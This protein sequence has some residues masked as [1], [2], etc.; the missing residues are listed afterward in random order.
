MVVILIAAAVLSMALGDHEDAIAIAAI[1]ALNALLGFSQEYRAE[2]AMSALKQLSIPIVR[3][4]RNNKVQ[5][6]SSRDVVPGDVVL[7]EAGERVAADCRLVEAARLETQEAALTGE[8]QPIQKNIEA[9]DQSELPLGDRHGMVYMGTFIVSGRGIGVAVA[10]GLATELGKIAR[11][12][13]SVRS[14]PTP[15]QHRLDQVGKRLA[16]IALFLVVVIFVLGMARGE[17]FRIMLL[18]AVSLGVAAVPEGLPAIVTIAL[19]LGAQRMLRRNALIR[20]LPAVEALGS[21]T[22]ICTDKTGTL[23]QNRM[24][25]ASLRTPQRRLELESHGATREADGAGFGLLLAAA[26]LCNDAFPGSSRNEGG[27]ILGDPTEVALLEAAGHFGIAKAH[28]ETVLPRVG[29]LPFSAERKRMTTFH[30]RQNSATAISEEIASALASDNEAGFIAFTKGA[31]E[32]LMECSAAIAVGDKKEV[33]SASWRERLIEENNELAQKGMRVLGIAYRAFPSLP[34]PGQMENAERDLTFIGMVAMMDPPRAEAALAV[35]T[36]KNAGI[37]PVMITGDHASTAQYIARQL[38]IDDGHPVVTGQE[39]DRL[40]PAAFDQRVEQTAV[41]AR[42]SPEHKLRIVEGLQRRGHIP[43]MT[44]DGVNDAPALRKAAI[45]VA[46]GKTGTDVAKESADM[47]LVDDNFATIVAAV[48]EGRVIYDN[49]RKFIKYILATNSGEICVML[50][51]PLV[52]MPLPLLPLQILWMNLV[53]DGLPALA[54][55]VEPAEEDAMRRPPYPPNESIFARGLGRHVIWVGLLMAVVSLGAGYA[56]WREGNASWQT[57]LFTTLTLS[58]MAHI[59]A[60]RT[61]RR[62]LFRA[63]LL[64][65]TP[66]LVAVVLTALLQ[67]AIVQIP[68]L[69]GTFG[70]IDL[71]GRDFALSLVLS[72]IIF[73][74]VE[75]EKWWIK[76]RQTSSAQAASG[77]SPHSGM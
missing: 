31:V 21:V 1:I 38:G 67:V 41:Y 66:L 26:A 54:L 17:S 16:I 7:L 32:N 49:I 25:V 12:L 75:L 37:R 29:E 69:Q 5:Q 47:V 44:G 71:S 73:W 22:A 48:E 58:Q 27:S 45:G 23:T 24:T 3:V 62:S 36:C 77:G 14:E 53:T 9:V 76:N 42:V 6:I 56:Y 18:T 11:L 64:S 55:G 39:L 60:I 50:I 57:M 63:G 35:A 33:L 28:L 34:P 40:S 59:M 72:S 65:N 13:Q 20:K 52:G 30:A 68:F 10:T 19:T 61:E 15:L 46:M 51:A 70:T 74:S 4:R 8:S 43:A 2:K